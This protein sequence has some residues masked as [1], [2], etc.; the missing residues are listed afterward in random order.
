MSRFLTG[1]LVLLTLLF[2]VAMTACQKT[3]PPREP[4]VL[5]QVN[6]RT[7]LLDDFRR[8]FERSMPEQQALNPEEREELK[9]NYLRQL[10]DGQLA[11]AEADRLNVQVSPT[12]VESLLEEFQRDYPAQEFQQMLQSQKISEQAWRKELI[13]RL[14]MEKVIRQ[15]VYAGL[16]VEESE[17]KTYFRQNRED[18]ERPE[19]VRARQIVVA[20]ED[21]GQR[22]LG[23]LR[24]EEP[25]AEVAQKYS[26][27]PDSEQGGDL[28]Y[29][30]RGQM[31]DAFDDVVF[32][33]PVGRLSDLVKTEYGYHIFLV[34]ERRKAQ[35]L[36]LSEV[37]DDIEML[38]RR[39]K[40]AN[41]YQAW[42]QK[43]GSEAVI[44]VDWSLL[45]EMPKP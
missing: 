27:S 43:L 4:Q 5:L 14:R 1:G 37:H 23:L 36:T 18:F 16:T 8:G 39:E 38:L 40:E 10:I 2:S 15:E 24:Q 20:R 9:R 21:E 7:L 42:L 6:G 31:P 11:L 25:F 12:E 34:E 41:A 30:S 3:E 19:Q 26:L 28:G 35:R 13:E 33:L 29:F 44:D 32:T 17:I 45:R 22:V